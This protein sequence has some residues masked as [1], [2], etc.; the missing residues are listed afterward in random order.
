MLELIMFDADGVLF[1]S[2]KA[3][4]A[5]YN[6]IFRRSGEQHLSEEEEQRCIFYSA[7]QLFESRALGDPNRIARMREIMKAL[8]HRLFFN[9]LRPYC[10]LRPF[11][12]E[13]KRTYR[14]GLAT[15]RAVTVPDLL[16]HLQLE[17]V[18]DA[19]A[20]ALDD[21][22]PKPAPDMIKLCLKRA[23]VESGR[24]VY[25]GDSPSD[26][27]AAEAAGTHFIAVG[28]RVE[29]HR[30]IAHIGELPSALENFSA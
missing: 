4:V 9:M 21:V 24:A 23:K 28:S 26:L 12:L 1:E 30:R 10:E 25:V 14:V 13:L 11:L 22:E 27:A 6:E 29:H 2:E 3:N 18:F 7:S 17:D 5:Y 8:D 16:A 19:I 20:S 15:N